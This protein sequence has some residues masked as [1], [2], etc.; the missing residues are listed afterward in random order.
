MTSREVFNLVIELVASAG[1]LTEAALAMFES[2]AAGNDEVLL[3]RTIQCQL[4]PAGFTRIMIASSNGDV[5]RLRKLLMDERGR[6]RPSSLDAVGLNSFG[7]GSHTA[8]SLAVIGGHEA[9]VQLLL[10]AGADP[11]QQLVV[12]DDLIESPLQHAVLASANTVGG[13]VNFASDDV[14][15]RAPSHPTA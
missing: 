4:G 7:D 8:L 12:V 9:V 15:R 5:H 13:G 14:C 1:H 3:E 10:D 2:P 11:I 6:F